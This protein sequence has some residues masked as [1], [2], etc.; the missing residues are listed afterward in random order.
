[1]QQH[2]NSSDFETVYQRYEFAPLVKLG[3]SVAAWV[4]ETVSGIRIRASAPEREKKG[5]PPTSIEPS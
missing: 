3:I 5:R 1:M 2:V 4:K